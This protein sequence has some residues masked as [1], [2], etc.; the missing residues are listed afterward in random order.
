[1]AEGLSA[2]CHFEKF[3]WHVQKD[4]SHDFL[5]HS[6]DSQDFGQ[7][8]Y[9]ADPSVYFVT[10]DT[11]LQKRIA[12]SPQATRVLQWRDLYKMAKG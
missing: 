8:H 4:A 5:K 12:A 11:K 7:L 1:M 10:E 3:L 2:A 6:S 9:L